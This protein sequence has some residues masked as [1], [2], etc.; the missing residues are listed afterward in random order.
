MKLDELNALVSELDLSNVIVKPEDVIVAIEG[1]GDLKTTFPIPNCSKCNASC[2]SSG[3]VGITLFDI[4]RLID[5][6]LDSFISGSFFETEIADIYYEDVK[7]IIYHIPYMLKNDSNPTLCVFLNEEQKCSMYE[8]RPKICS[9]YPIKISVNKNKQVIAS[10]SIF[11][12]YY[13]IV[14]NES[15]FQTLFLSA[16]QQHNEILISRLLV[17]HS[18]KRIR[19]IGLGKYIGKNLKRVITQFRCSN[20]AV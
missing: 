18:E 8:K 19:D 7:N 10:W 13:D 4:A 3:A 14:D 6:G 5:N 11:C 2:C 9:A 16:I 17:E 1:K 20:G 12:K 15:A